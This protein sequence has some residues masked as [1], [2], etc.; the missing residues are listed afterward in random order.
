VPLKLELRNDD[1]GRACATCGAGQLVSWFQLRPDPSRPPLPVDSD[2]EL[3][4][5]IAAQDAEIAALLDGMV[6]PEVWRPLQEER[7]LAC[8]AKV[9]P[10]VARLKRKVLFGNSGPA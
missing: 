10:I 9:E 3:M 6:D 7:R 2:E 4:A 1:D 8:A 5:R